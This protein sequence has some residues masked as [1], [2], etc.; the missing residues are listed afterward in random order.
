MQLGFIDFHFFVLLFIFYFCIT[1]FY[2]KI[3]CLTFQ[4]QLD[5]SLHSLR[6]SRQGSHLEATISVLVQC[7]VDLLQGQ[8]VDFQHHAFAFN[9]N[10]FN[11]SC[12][13][14]QKYF[15]SFL[16]ILMFCRCIYFIDFKSCS[17]VVRKHTSCVFD[18]FLR[19]V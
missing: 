10:D 19:S 9:Q 3:Y 4:V 18:I 12:S 16:E 14:V 7:F 17:G 2:S 6:H 15:V 8:G 11:L 5:A 1:N 13:W